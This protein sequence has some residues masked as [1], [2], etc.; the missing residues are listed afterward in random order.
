MNKPETLKEHLREDYFI[1]EVTLV[2][3]IWVTN[4][5][6]V[7]HIPEYLGSEPNTKKAVKQFMGNLPDTEKDIEAFKDAM[8]HYDCTNPDDIY[9]IK[10]A[11][12]LLDVIKVMV[13]IKK[14]LKDNPDTNHLIMYVAA[15]HGMN[16]S[17]K[18]VFL[19]NQ[20][21]PGSKFYKWFAIEDNIRSI[22]E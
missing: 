10:D 21:H 3:Y 7:V 15:G 20:F 13:E 16:E 6:E 11:T 1:H 4:F 14:R 12:N 17:G 2:V 19:I 9:E 5:D 8:E 18:Q 22:S